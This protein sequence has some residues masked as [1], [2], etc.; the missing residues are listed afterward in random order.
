MGRESVTL[1]E[2]LQAS[3]REAEELRGEVRRH[4]TEITRLE[5]HNQ[6]YKGWWEYWES[7]HNQAAEQTAM[8]ED[9]VVD[10][11]AKYAELYKRLHQLDERGPSTRGSGEW[12]SHVATRGRSQSARLMPDTVTAEE[13]REALEVTRK[14]SDLEASRAAREAAARLAEE[15]EEKPQRK[16]S[17]VPSSVPPL[18]LPAG[19]VHD[20]E[21]SGEDD[22]D[23]TGASYRSYGSS[24][25]SSGGGGGGVDNRRIAA[26]GAGE[27]EEEEEEEAKKEA[28]RPGDITFDDADV[29]AVTAAE[30]EGS[31][32]PD[33]KKPLVPAAG[34]GPACCG[35][36]RRGAGASSCVIS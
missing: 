32:E 26:T 15:E 3:R 36:N 28:E 9:E 19:L 30:E 10:A 35:Y 34:S 33:V 11:H 29:E 17:G 8:L 25:S 21:L 6:A 16:G 5:N 27:E 18:Q 22:A 14:L 4:E 7:K 20:S 23:R 31:A 2:R 12:W 1:Q 13:A 24:S